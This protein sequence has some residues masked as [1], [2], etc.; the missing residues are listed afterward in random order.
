M[1]KDYRRIPNYDEMLVYESQRR[2]VI[3]S[4][5]ST[6]DVINTYEIFYNKDI[7]MCFVND[8]IYFDDRLALDSY[9]AEQRY[10]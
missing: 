10:S 8:L 3:G 1:I 2:L 6:I 7:S 5:A 4:V 9:E